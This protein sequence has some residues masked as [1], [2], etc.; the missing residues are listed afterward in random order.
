MQSIGKSLKSAYKICEPDYTDDHVKEL[1]EL[2]IRVNFG[3]HEKADRGTYQHNYHRA[4]G[5]LLG[6]DRYKIK[7][8]L[9]CGIWVGLGLLTWARYF[10][11]CMV[12]GI[13]KEF[14]WE[15]KI[16]RLFEL[17]GSYKLR[18]NWCDTTNL[19]MVRRHFNIERYAKYYDIIFDDG[20]HFA[21]GQ[22]ATLI[23]L[24]DYLKPGG[25]YFIEDIHERFEPCDKLLEFIEDLSSEGHEVGWFE[26]PNNLKVNFDSNKF[27]GSM[28]ESNLIAI[29]K[30][31]LTNTQEVQ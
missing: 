27:A 21:S 26:Y 7:N 13:D 11:N 8:V 14:Q 22:K 29:R 6:E 24:W 23:N 20:N 3:K 25:W 2:M 5:K 28:H 31:F 16:K 4:Y 30:K 17:D 10:P 19:E 12:D 15:R 18:L 1:D 9:E